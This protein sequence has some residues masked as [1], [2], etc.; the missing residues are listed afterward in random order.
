MVAKSLSRRWKEEKQK[1]NESR[2][3]R[4]LKREIWND[5]CDV[6]LEIRVEN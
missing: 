4:R 3:S 6:S 2:R 1:E 5:L